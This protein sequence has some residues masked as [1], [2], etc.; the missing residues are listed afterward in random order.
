M[1]DRMYID[2][3]EILPDVHPTCTNAT[4]AREEREIF[5]PKLREAGW[6]VVGPWY[7]GDGDSFGPLTRCAHIR[8][9]GVTKTVVY[10]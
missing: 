9:D 2:L 6:G 3:N 10:G 8:K 7:T 1:S 4:Y 5:T